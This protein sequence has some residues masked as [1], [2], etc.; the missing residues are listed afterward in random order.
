M[1]FDLTSEQ[2]ALCEMVQN[3]GQNEIAPQLD[4]LEEQ[5]QFPTDIFK[6][7]SELQLMG[8]LTPETYQGAN[9]DFSTYAMVLE[10][11]A[12]YSLSVAVSLSVTV[13]PMILLAHGTEEQKKKYLCDLATGK[14]LGAF[15]LTEANSGSDAGALKTKAELK[16]D[17]YLING[18]KCFVTNGKVADTYLVMAR[19]SEDKSKGI[20]AFIVEKGMA[21]FSFGKE[22]EKMAMKSSPTLELIFKDCKVPKENLVGKE[23]QGFK[24][25]LQALNSG[26]I[27]MAACAVGIAQRAFEE[28]RDYAKMRTQFGRPISQLQAIQM[29]LADMATS[30]EYS[31]LLVKKAAYL[32]DQ[33]KDYVK[34]ASMAKVA[35]TDMAMNVTTKAVQIFGGNGYCQDYPVERLMREAKVLQIVEGTNQIQRVI[36]ARE[37][38]V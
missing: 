2:Q 19:T 36:I 7:L 20:S 13:L 26:R 14:K 15:S 34:A 32:R 38:L 4:A 35:A 27:T 24:V 5:G 23:G 10:Q 9:L 18:T 6:K 25:A 33:K 22:E 31:R 16:G 28:A 30:I 8:M 29:M 17:H 21:G 12:K 11:I 37:I 3:F 1:S